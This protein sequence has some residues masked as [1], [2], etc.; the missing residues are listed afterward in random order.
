[1]PPE[2][3]KTK[4]IRAYKELYNGSDFEVHYQYA[5]I[6]VIVWV[7]FLFAPGI[8]ILFPIALLG[9]IVQLVTNKIALAYC[10]KRPPAYNCSLNRN[11]LRTLSLAPFLYVA[12]GAWVYSNQQ[13]FR[14][15][16]SPMKE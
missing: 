1:M 3:T 14:S 8:P 7:T 10:V 12:V 5:Q 2:S 9:L 16:V 6:L 13:V 15:I 4:T 11:M